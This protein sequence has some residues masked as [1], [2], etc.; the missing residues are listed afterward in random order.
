MASGLR[1]PSRLPPP[2]V[3]ELGPTPRQHPRRLGVGST[4]VVGFA[5]PPGT[6]WTLLDMCRVG[7]NGIVVI[8]PVNTV[9]FT[10]TPERRERT[11][12]I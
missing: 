4:F 1:L 12:W 8:V 10:G 2:C 7:S 6:W 9:V 5:T 11:D 3:S